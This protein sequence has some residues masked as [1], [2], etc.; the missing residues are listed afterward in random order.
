[1]QQL[2]A[3]L[4]VVTPPRAPVVRRRRWSRQRMTFWSVLYL[5]LL[6]TVAGLVLFTYYPKADVVIRAFY[7]W[8]PPNVQEFIGWRN[9][10]D[11]LHDPLFWQSFKLVGIL[12]AASLLKMWPS[13]FAAIALHRLLN[14][15]WRYVY[16][17]LFVVPMVIP[18]LVWLLI[19]KSF[20]DPDY[21]LLNRFLNATGM[22]R[23]LAVLDG[24]PD[25]PGW[26]PR[27]AQ[28]L[29]PVLDHVV[30]PLFGGLGVMLL[31]GAL[32]VSAAHWLRKRRTTGSRGRPLSRFQR[33]ARSGGWALIGS[34]SILILLTQ[35]WDHPT[36]QFVEGVP[37]WLGSKDLVVPALLF[38]GF[39]WV[40]TVGV[41]IYLAGLQQ[42]SEEV[43][44]AAELDGVG[45]V[46]KL[47]RIELP[48]IMTQ[49]RINLIF[50][51][52]HTL[53][54]YELFLILLGVEGGPGN[55]GMVPGL[56]MYKKAFDEGR[57]GYACAVGMVLFVVIMS[58]TLLY[59]RFLKVEK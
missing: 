28:A 35:V 56:Y 46:G 33:I 31:A 57:F 54:A 40:G 23:V 20:Y 6:P 44:E 52:I 22:M 36:G 32:I 55:R 13:I 38:W 12:L 19:W 27:L 41:L 47:F 43:Y 9:F 37:A 34:A 49:I 26:M 30:T 24:T 15:R 58:L 11:V 10:V 39:P 16:Q 51:T 29:R 48:L 42:I 1:M 7:R 4:P 18:A 2:E 50:M 5:L 53:S 3:P 25:A 17:V 14:A 45:P 8:E 21:G 59:Q